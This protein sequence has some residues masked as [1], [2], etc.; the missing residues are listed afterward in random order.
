[1]CVVAIAWRA[2]PRWRLVMAGNRDE[3]HARPTAALAKWDVAPHV[4]AGRDLQSG[5]SWVGV[6]AEG[7]FAVV[8]NVRMG[9]APDPSLRSRG[10][11]VR[12]W[13]EAGQ[14]EVGL[15][16]FGPFN[17]IVADADGA[18]IS[19][20]RPGPSLE[21]LAVGIHA[22]SNGALGEDWPRQELLKA[23]FAN[24]LA[25]PDDLDDLFVLLQDER[26]DGETPPIFIRDGIYGTRASTVVAL[27]EDGSGQIIERRFG[28][29][30]VAQGETCFDFRWGDAS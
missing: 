13:L 30:G 5:G 24:W 6:S 29:D 15:A 10:A 14:M 4:M 8:T 3:Y 1:M 17:L 25:Q 27:G 12:N 16:D 21:S 23:S 18:R 7:R 19:T 2:H 20:N 28:P 26:A 11:L 9:T 22:L